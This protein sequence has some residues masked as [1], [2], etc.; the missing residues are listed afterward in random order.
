MEAK[1][2]FTGFLDR[3]GLSE[4]FARSNVLVFP[5]QFPEPFGI[6]QVEALAAGLVVVSSGTGGAKEIIRDDVDGLLFSAG[7]EADLANKLSRLA[8]D[9]VLMT[10]LQRSAQ[11]RAITFS[12]ENA[13]RKIEALATD[14]QA[15]LAAAPAGEFAPASQP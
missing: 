10:R 4:L 11:S 15:A 7:N 1:V 9:R 8:R 2:R 6:S 14:M 3:R 13:V 12:V 5:S